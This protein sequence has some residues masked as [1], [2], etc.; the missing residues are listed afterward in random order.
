MDFFNCYSEK[1]VVYPTYRITDES[2]KKHAGI[3]KFQPQRFDPK[4]KV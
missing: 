3:T 2:L 4:M 1:E